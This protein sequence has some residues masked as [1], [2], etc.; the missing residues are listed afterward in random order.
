MKK[1]LIALSLVGLVTTSC[2]EKLNITPPNAITNEQVMELL[3]NGN[4]ETVTTIMGAMADGLNAEFK[5]TGSLNGWSNEYYTYAQALD[6]NRSFAGN[7]M[8]LSAQPPTGDDL[9]MYNFTSLRTSDNVTNEPFWIRGYDLVQAANKVFNLLTDE[10]VETNGNVKLKDYQGR[11]YLT[12][13]YG[14]LFL[15]E[16]LS[17]R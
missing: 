9:A 10:L 7:D 13:A 12:R 17:K 1:Y 4:D 5:H 8:V 3:K 16:I 2:Y 14:Y 15:M 11:A 6:V